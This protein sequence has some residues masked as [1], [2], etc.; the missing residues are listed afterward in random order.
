[1]LIVLF[2]SVMVAMIL[3]RNLT[4]DISR[5]VASRESREAVWSNRV[6]GSSGLA[7]AAAEK[8]GASGR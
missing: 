6:D 8:S 2:L 1:M 5:C 4:R 3:V 7:A